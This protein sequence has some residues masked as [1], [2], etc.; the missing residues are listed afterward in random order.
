MIAGRNLLWAVVWIAVSGLSYAGGVTVITHGLNGQVDGWL[1]SMCRSL[2]VHPRVPGTNASIYRVSV[3]RPSGSYVVTASSEKVNQPMNPSGEIIVAVDWSTIAGLFQPSTAQIAVP[4]ASALR[5]TT[6]IPELGGRP[7]VELPLH[8]VGHSRGASMMAEVARLLGAEGIW[9]DHLTLLDPYP[10]TLANSDPTLRNY[11][12][13]FFTE[14]FRQ[15][16]SFPDG[17]TLDGAYERVLTGLTAGGYEA[18]AEH[19]DVH[20]WYHGTL[21]FRTPLTVDGVTIS[22][23]ERTNWWTAMEARGV[24]AGFRYSLIGG[25]DRFLTNDPAGS[26]GKVADGI[27]QVWDFGAGLSANRTALAV[28]N[29]AWPNVIQLMLRGRVL[30]EGALQAEARYQHG[31]TAADVAELS[32]RL[33]PDLNPWNTNELVAGSVALP[34]TGTASVGLCMAEISPPEGIAPG[35][36]H[37]LAR[38]ARGGLQRWYYAQEM[39]VSPPVLANPDMAGNAFAFDLLGKAGWKVTIE[40]STDFETW[41]PART[42]IMSSSAERVSVSAN[43]DR[44]F[45]RAVLE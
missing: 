32:L 25:G 38:T 44:M 2:S 10:S 13:V 7:L 30:S 37:V 17:V 43:G 20:L 28:N 23:A 12:N 1:L 16:Y 19:S 15:T 41:T 6:L 42:N 14:N 27:N 9:V 3:T 8:L 22:E 5:S 36:Y 39:V 29:G 11:A 33:D 4:V 45:F 34:G 35:E 21:D 24:N 26:P 18:G 31:L 40:E